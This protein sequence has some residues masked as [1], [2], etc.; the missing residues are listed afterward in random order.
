M[1]AVHLRLGVLRARGA[2]GLVVGDHQAAVVGEVEPVDDAAHAEFADARLES[3]L[4]ADV[5]DGGGVFHR[6]VALDQR[7]AVGEEGL[8]RGVGQVE[9]GEVGVGVVLGDRRIGGETSCS[10]GALGGG[11]GEEQLEGSVDE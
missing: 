1:D 11:A 2:A 8:C 3:Q 7:P 9:T 4:E 6:E 5:A 10:E